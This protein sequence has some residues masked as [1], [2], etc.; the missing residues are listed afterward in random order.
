[1]EPLRHLGRETF[2]IVD[3]KRGIWKLKSGKEI[4]DLSGG[5]LLET[6]FSPI[7]MSGVPF[8]NIGASGGIETNLRIK[9]ENE[10][11]RRSKLTDRNGILWASSGSDAIEFSIWA[12]QE[13]QRASKIICANR[14]PAFIVRLGGYH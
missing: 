1:M 12:I 4:I 8:S 6:L 14:N 5:P 13:K 7:S 10:V 9:V 11:L 3:K 2:T